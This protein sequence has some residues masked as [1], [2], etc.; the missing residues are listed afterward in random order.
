MTVMTKYERVTVVAS[1]IAVVVSIMVGFKDNI[2]AAI[3]PSN[4]QVFPEN[5]IWIG[6]RLG[7]ITAIPSIV[8]ANDGQSDISIGRIQGLIKFQ[9]GGEIELVADS[10][11]K[12]GSTFY[13]QEVLIKPKTVW[14]E[15]IVFNEKLSFNTEDQLRHLEEKAEKSARKNIPKGNSPNR[16][17]LEFLKV[18]DMSP[19]ATGKGPMFSQEQLRQFEEI[20]QKYDLTDTSVLPDGKILEEAKGIFDKNLSRLE[21]GQHSLTLQIF[22]RAE[23]KIWEGKYKFLLFDEQIMRLKESIGSFGRIRVDMNFP[24]GIPDGDSTSVEIKLEPQSK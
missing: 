15:R 1:A 3:Y 22:D 6:N 7:F 20:L 8:I 4:A 14:S 16:M 23:K 13:L 12:N 17:L 10:Y 24:R 18:M 5:R 2:L 11:I 19:A 9:S 21:K